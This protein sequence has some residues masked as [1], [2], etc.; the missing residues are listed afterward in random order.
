MASRYRGGS[1][2]RPVERTIEA[3][4]ES[5]CP[6][7]EFRARYGWPSC[8]VCGAGSERVGCTYGVG[9]AGTTGGQG[10]GG[11]QLEGRAR[12]PER[13]AIPPRTVEGR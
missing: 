9:G 7:A 3:A 4:Q 11:V 2:R 1:P 13:D 10:L 6:H 8:R 5:A 12:V